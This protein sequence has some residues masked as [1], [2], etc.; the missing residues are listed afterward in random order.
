M[1]PA[2]APSTPASNRL[3]AIIHAQAVIDGPINQTY[4]RSTLL[5]LAGSIALSM[6][7]FGIVMPVFARR[8]GELGGGIEALGY[9]TVA[10]ATA[11]LIVSPLAGTLA[12][13]IGRRPVILLALF[14]FAATNI[15]YLLASSTWTFIILRGLAG[16]LTT[17][18]TPAAMGVVADTVPGEERGRWAGILMGGY[19]AGLIFGPVLGGLLYD[20]WGFAAP[21]LLSA[22]IGAVA[23]LAAFIM[24]PE[25]RTKAIRH[26]EALQ[27]RYAATRGIRT[28][29]SRW[30]SLPRPLYSFALLLLID[31]A[32]AFA[33]A[34][35]EPQMIFYVYEQ[36]HWSTVQFGVVVATYGVALLAGQSLL[37]Q[38]SDRLGRKP[39]LLAG[40][41][42]NTS[43]YLGLAM[44][45]YYPLVLVTALVAGL[46]AGLMAPALSA[47]Y[48]DMSAP[49][50]QARIMG[51]KN[52]ALGLGGVVGPLLVVFVSQ[53]TTPQ[54]IFLTAAVLLLGVLVTTL[55]LL[56]LPTRRQD[57]PL[58][59][60]QEFVVGRGLV[61]QAVLNGLV[62]QAIDRR[63]Q[64]PA[65][66]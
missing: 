41:L 12:D 55:L 42:L 25:S 66:R 30:A 53:W 33:F 64:H 15:G 6:T 56:R 17:G 23:F 63:T 7:G 19:G 16:A 31:F 50:H 49:Q 52:S 46:G 5:L 21:F 36:L 47:L 26:R 34:F 45:T 18:L 27:Q 32:G 3:G 29:H 28:N 54:G 24:V 51:V 61:A 1:K 13:R 35:V 39:V 11:Q 40:L 10:F 44:V 14:A 8:L 37:G 2:E 59:A 4:S 38:I 43:L 60:S 48:L 20:T 62:I 22:A 57:E 9:M 65:R 58:L